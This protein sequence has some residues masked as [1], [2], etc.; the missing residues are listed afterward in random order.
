MNASIEFAKEKYYHNTVNN[1][2][3]TQKNYKVYWSLLKI[4]LNNKKIPIIPAL[5]NENRFITDFKEKAQL[6]IFS[7]VNN[8]PLFLIIAL[9]LLMLTILLTNAYLQLHFQPD[10]LEKSFKIFI[11]TKPM[12]MI[13]Y[14]SAS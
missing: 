11:Q 3:N 6:L 10:I 5:F 12:D 13:T 2:M 9:F 8:D 4:F 1:L 14:V 7:F